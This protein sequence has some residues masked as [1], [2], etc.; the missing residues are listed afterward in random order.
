MTFK[1]TPKIATLLAYTVLVSIWL[2]TFFVGIIAPPFFGYYTVDE[3]YIPDSGVFLWYGNTPRCLDW[4]AT[5]SLLTF[6]ILFGVKVAWEIFSHLGSLQGILSVF[7]RLDLEAFHY[8][9]SR[10]EFILIGR[11]IQ[12]VEVGLILILI[13]RFLTRTSHDLLTTLTR[14]LLIFLIIT[15]Y[16]VWFNA[17]VLRPEALAGTLFI[18]LMLRLVFVYRITPNQAYF[19]AAIFGVILAERLLFVFVAP[20][21]LGG[22]Y[23]LSPQHKFRTTFRALGILLAVFILLCPFIFTDPLV[24]MKSFFGG[25]L[26]KMQDK[27]METLFNMSYIGEYFS[28]PVA[29]LI[30]LATLAGIGALLW[31]KKPFY[32]VLV[33]TWFLY[34]VMVLRSAKIYDTH[35]LPAGILTLIVLALGIGTLASRL[36]S[37]GKYLAF[38]LAVLIMGNNLLAYFQFQE[39][40]HTV[41]NL[42]RAYYWMQELPVDSRFLVHPELEVYLPKSL[43]QVA[44]EYEQNRDS[45]KMIQKLNYLMGNRGDK[46]IEASRLPLVTSSFAFEDERLYDIQ[47][48]LLLKYGNRRKGRVFDYD[49]YLENTEL[50]NHSVRTQEAIRDFRAGKYDYMITELRLDGL[51]PV[52]VFVNNLHEPI[53]CY[54]SPR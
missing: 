5:P 6:F 44:R 41:S 33:G 14:P 16:V 13:I 40:S 45:T 1:F 32:Y 3:N 31:A 53:F 54:Q 9:V 12:L 36:P 15:S 2:Y 29:Y 17:P 49:V 18:Y 35:V 28:N 43:A 23:F 8:F 27:P 38:G 51:E 26:A 50:A 39:R 24:V 46:A 37:V 47:Y 19:L 7:E 52:Q 34:L 4:P 48:Q 30:V 11:A 21:V 10:T 22:I 25:I 20:I 42:E